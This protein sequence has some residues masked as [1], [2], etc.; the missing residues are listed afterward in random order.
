MAHLLAAVLTALGLI[1]VDVNGTWKGTLTPDGRDPTPALLVLK[2]DGTTITGT[3]GANDTDRHPI[4]QGTIKDDLVTLDAEVGEGT[5]KFELKLQ[6]DEL[7]GAVIRE[8]DG[9]QQKATLAVK[10][11]K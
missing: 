5:M 11:E 9:Q 1:A 10:R 6:G 4:R 8:R 3:V 2:Q 7:T